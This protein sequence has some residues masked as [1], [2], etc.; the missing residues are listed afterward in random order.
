MKALFRAVVLL[1]FLV[2]SLAAQGIPHVVWGQIGNADG[3]FPPES[4]VSFCCTLRPGTADSETICWPNALPNWSYLEE[5]GYWVL[6]CAD[7]TL[8]W[9]TGDSLFLRFAFGA[10]TTRELLLHAV[11]NDD[12]SQELPFQVPNYRPVLTGQIPDTSLAED[13]IL[14]WDLTPWA[15]DEEDTPAELHWIISGW[16]STLWENISA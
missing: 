1:P 16:D 6:Q 9:E 5:S 12:P 8:G 7:F 15:E 14:L 3:S 10:D 2:S 13:T 11:L 4:E